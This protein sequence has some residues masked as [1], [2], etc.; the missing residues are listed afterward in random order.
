[1]RSSTLEATCTKHGLT[2]AHR[3]FAKGGTELSTK[4]GYQITESVSYLCLLS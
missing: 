3:K 2:S 4:A 1:M